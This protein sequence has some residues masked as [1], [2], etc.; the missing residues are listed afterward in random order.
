L[1]T[2]QAKSNKKLSRLASTIKALST[3]RYVCHKYLYFI[4]GR[5]DVWII[6][7]ESNWW[8][9]PCSSHT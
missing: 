2:C 3:R 8:N 7:A 9:K 6:L 4:D 1:E 5:K